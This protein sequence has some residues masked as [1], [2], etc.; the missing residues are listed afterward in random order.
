MPAM[1]PI[2]ADPTTAFIFGLSLVFCF[3]FL[4][5]TKVNLVAIMDVM[6]SPA[7]NSMAIGDGLK[8]VFSPRNGRQITSVPRKAISPALPPTFG[9]LG[10][11]EIL[12]ILANADAPIIHLSVGR[13]SGEAMPTNAPQ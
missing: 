10:P 11:M 6:M 1:R 5:I 2:I 7:I 13:I 3:I 9:I 8:M 4:R 12:I